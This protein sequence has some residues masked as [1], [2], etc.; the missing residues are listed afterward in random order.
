MP[1]DYFNDP[2]ERATGES[3]ATSPHSLMF[4]R[5]VSNLQST[6][7]EEVFFDD[8]DWPEGF[9]WRSEAEAVWAGL[10]EDATLLAT[11]RTCRPD[12]RLLC[13]AA[14]V[15][16]R[17]I[18]AG[19]PAELEAARIKLAKIMQKP[20]EPRIHFMLEEAGLSLE[21]MADRAEVEGQEP[22]EADLGL[23]PE[24]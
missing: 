11:F 15:I 8:S 21:Q 13:R 24:A 22:P 14:G 2:I 19:S 10:A 3:F 20:A 16:H 5:L 9:D 4:E 23:T 17:A 1:K 6:L 7:D 18:R 12:D